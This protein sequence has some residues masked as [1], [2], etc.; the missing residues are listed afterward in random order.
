MALW[1]P[2]RVTLFLGIWCVGAVVACRNEVS[3]PFGASCIEPPLG[4][5]LKVRSELCQSVGSASEVVSVSGGDDDPCASTLSPSAC[6]Y[7]PAGSVI[8]N[9]TRPSSESTEI[10]PL[11]ISM[12]ERVITRPGQ[13]CRRRLR[14]GTDRG[15]KCAR[16]GVPAGCSG[17]RRPSLRSK[18][19]SPRA[20]S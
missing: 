5:I 9:V 1:T 16:I 15:G 10:C 17:S 19:R 3:C 2:G 6:R 14:V 4:I 7:Q 20:R 18:V 8:K 11:C 12:I 13:H